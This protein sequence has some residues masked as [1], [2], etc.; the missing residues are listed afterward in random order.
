MK[1]K[2][3]IEKANNIATEMEEIL[4]GC[5]RTS[6]YLSQLDRQYSWM[7]RNM[8]KS[9]IYKF[10]TIAT[11]EYPSSILSYFVE[12]ISTVF[13]NSYFVYKEAKELIAQESIFFE[14][15]EIGVATHMGLYLFFCNID[16]VRQRII[17]S[18][19][20]EIQSK[21]L[22]I[23]ETEQKIKET[24]IEIKKK[25]QEIKE[26][27]QEL[28]KIEKEPKELIPVTF[29]TLTG[30]VIEYREKSNLPRQQ[31]LREKRLQLIEKSRLLES[32]T[33]KSNEEIQNLNGDIQKLNRDTHS[34]TSL[35]ENSI[36]YLESLYNDFN[37]RQ[38]DKINNFKQLS[39]EYNK[40]PKKIC[41]YI[42]LL[43]T[44]SW[45][46]FEFTKD[47]KIDFDEKDKM[48]LVD[49]LLP[50][51]NDIPNNNL[52]HTSRSEEWTSL[53]E[54]KFNKIYDDIIYAVVIRTLAEIVHYDENNYIKSICLNGINRG[55][56][57]AT[58]V[59]ED[60]AFLSI[61]VSTSQIIDLDLKHINPKLCF[62]HLKG[63]S[64]SK[65]YEHVAITPILTTKLHD[66]RI[67]DSK[68]IDISTAD[69]L[70]EMDWEDFEHLVRQIF[71]WEFSN[72]D[73]EVR[74]T[75]SSRDGGVD[76]IVFDPDPIRGGK[77]II[78]AKRYTNTIPVSAVRDLYGTTINE[79]AN[80]GILITTSDYGADSCK[81]AQGKN[82]TLLN[83]GHILYLLNKHGK[84][85]H[86]N[87]EEAKRKQRE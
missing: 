27:E 20:N 24:E 81:F 18:N 44:E 55:Y 13:P 61:M 58:G 34:R 79:G 48:L 25:E 7:G 84:K 46:P 87:I 43:L 50:S 29:W 22:R 71:E 70:A 57:P 77:I 54:S 45:Y 21:K 51:K 49:Y 30:K 53:T 4:H 74:V 5:F 66:K 8:E 9:S 65:L 31:K 19:E 39:S 73:S 36:S 86:I 3:I 42:E 68:Y 52:K 56:N 69:N 33:L 28:T 23:K 47:I 15:Y 14:P 1:L 60:K 82:L 62:K 12:D 85:A 63:V 32:S 26:T 59:L 40:S 10:R 67:I 16:E 17:G 2:Y 11:S 75:Q 83:G 76:A 38:L 72:S 6:V 37:N 80:K 41:D 35:L 64:A 78:Q